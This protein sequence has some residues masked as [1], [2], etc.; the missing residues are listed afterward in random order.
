MYILSNKE[1]YVSQPGEITCIFFFLGKETTQQIKTWNRTE[2]TQFRKKKQWLPPA[3][4]QKEFKQ[5]SPI[6]TTV[7]S[8]LGLSWTECSMYI[9]FY[10]FHFKII[11]ARSRPI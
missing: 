9:L 4:N 6:V 11:L 7:T 5:M 10:C 1:T 2:T 8:A 3:G